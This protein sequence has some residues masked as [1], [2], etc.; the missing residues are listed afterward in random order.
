[1]NTLICD[2]MLVVLLF[3]TLDIKKHTHSRT[4]TLNCIIVLCIVRDELSNF[5]CMVLVG[6][7]LFNLES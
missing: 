2:I 6:C 4:A 5:G 3:K 7:F 1:M